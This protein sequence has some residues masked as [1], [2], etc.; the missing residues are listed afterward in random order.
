[1]IEIDCICCG[2]EIS[3]RAHPVAPVLFSMCD[4]CIKEIIAAGLVAEADSA[5]SVPNYSN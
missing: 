2:A 3:E 5:S 4:A 1:M